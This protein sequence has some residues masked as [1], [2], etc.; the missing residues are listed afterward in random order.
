MLGLDAIGTTLQRREA[1][2]AFEARHLQEN[3]WLV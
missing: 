3:P 1:I 2:E